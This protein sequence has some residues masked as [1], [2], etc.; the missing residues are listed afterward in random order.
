MHNG[1]AH[2][3]QGRPNPWAFFRGTLLPI[4]N[5]FAIVKVKALQKTTTANR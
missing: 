1:T 4:M 2:H 3:K 5:E